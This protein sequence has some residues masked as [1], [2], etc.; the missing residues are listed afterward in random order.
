MKRRLLSCLLCAGTFAGSALASSLPPGTL[1][2]VDQ[3][4]GTQHLGSLFTVN[5]SNGQRIVFSDFSN[6]SQGVTGVDPNGVAWLPGQL[7]GLI[8]GS[9]LVTD[10]SG[11]TDERGALYRIDPS[12]GQRTLFSDF[13]NGLQGPLGIY[14]VSVLAVPPGL[15]SW[16]GVLVCD[17]YA[18]TNGQGA[19][20]SVDTN[21]HRTVL[22]DFGDG[23][24]PQ[25]TYPDSMALYGGLLGLGRTV[26]VADGSAGTN[27]HGALFSVD[28]LGKTRTV[29]SDFGDSSEGWVD[30]NP[31]STPVGIAV[32][33]SN[34]VYVLVDEAGTGGAGAL[35]E[36]NATTGY[37][38]LVS[39]FG[40]AT[41]G[42]IGASP[43]GVTWLANYGG[44]GVSDSLAGTGGNGTVFLVNPATGARTTLSDFGN[45]AQGAPGAEPS[46]LAVIQ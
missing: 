20:F 38:T 22:I 5:Q 39:D 14:P 27:Q 24:G 36:V 29:I 31:L 37:R 3:T 40:N 1:L 28:P 9:V 13:G 19:L 44:L 6:T 25:G 8:P 42:T 2:A 10:G 34:Q 43:S 15:L 32:S 46:G 17:P 45:T 30:P 4:A 11:G 26:L 23:N 33:P 35:V 18:G 16:S 7:L 12:T 21:G 41:Q